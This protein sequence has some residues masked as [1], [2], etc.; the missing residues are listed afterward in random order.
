MIGYGEPPARSPRT[1]R[2]LIAA[3]PLEH[4]GKGDCGRDALC[5]TSRICVVASTDIAFFQQAA[6]E[7]RFASGISETARPQAAILS[8]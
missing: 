8:L 1:N 5:E 2:V 6:T 7:H 3:G 4:V